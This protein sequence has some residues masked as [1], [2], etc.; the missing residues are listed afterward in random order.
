VT[1]PISDIAN[2]FHRTYIFIFDSLGSQH[3][4]AL[5]N[6]TAYLRME[7]KYK[8]GI[9]ATGIINFFHFIDIKIL[10]SGAIPDKSL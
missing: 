10:Y 5:K 9:D 8:K 2:S 1:T 6:L 4:Q 3:P 7:A